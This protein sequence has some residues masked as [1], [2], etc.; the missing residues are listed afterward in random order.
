M[1]I[2]HV[3]L[4]NFSKIVRTDKMATR[5]H[6]GYLQSKSATQLSGG[7]SSESGYQEPE[8]GPAAESR[9]LVRRCF[10]TRNTSLDMIESQFSPCGGLSM[11]PLV[12]LAR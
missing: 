12:I 7:F 8:I 6:Y 9:H 4:D 1:W 2:G 5:S 10:P 11:L 3:G